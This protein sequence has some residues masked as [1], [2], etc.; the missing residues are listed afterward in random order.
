[1]RLHEKC[2]TTHYDVLGIRTRPDCGQ[3]RGAQHWRVV[4]DIGGDSH[5]SLAWPRVP[6]CAEAGQVLEGRYVKIWR[7]GGLEIGGLEIGGWRDY[8][9]DEI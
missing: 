1:M 6:V 2:S 3:L 5:A 9:M 8:L 7:I 4:R